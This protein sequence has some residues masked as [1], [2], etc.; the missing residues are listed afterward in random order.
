MSSH[1]SD[2]PAPTLWSISKSLFAGGVAG[3]MCVLLLCNIQRANLAR[4]LLA[5]LLSN[6]AAAKQFVVLAVQEQQLLP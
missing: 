4:D 3:G 5:A 1:E 6:A 2:K